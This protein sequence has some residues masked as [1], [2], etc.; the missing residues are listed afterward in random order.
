MVEQENTFVETEHLY[1]FGHSTISLRHD[2][3]VEIITAPDFE[4]D[5]EHIKQNHAAIKEIAKNKRV[6]ILS[7]VGENS[8]ASKDVR[9][10]VAKA[11][12]KDFVKAEAFVIQ[13]LAQK[14]LANFFI[15]VN[16]PIVPAKF[17]KNVEDAEKWLKSF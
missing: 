13:S 2:G 1:D 8:T 4:Y 12:H 10:F 11:P 16:K 15:K 9:E 7:I 5:V 17:F 3:I 6:L 14:L